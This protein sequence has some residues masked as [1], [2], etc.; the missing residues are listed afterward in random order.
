MTISND[1]LTREIE[2]ILQ[3]SKDVV[4]LSGTTAY[5]ESIL[6]RNDDIFEKLIIAVHWYRNN[7]NNLSLLEQ[8]SQ[9][10]WQTKDINFASAMTYDA[11]QALLEGLRRSGNNP[12]RKRL[13]DELSKPN[14]VV[15]G[16]KTKVRFNK[17]HDRIVNQQNIK[18][19]LFLVSPKDGEFQ[20]I[21]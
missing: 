14:F 10:L 8:R 13:Y 5:L 16:A 18:D 17:D 21:K 2:K 19:L 6:N 11:T 9:K 4:I 1:I 12:T 7:D 15:E 20:I 3:S